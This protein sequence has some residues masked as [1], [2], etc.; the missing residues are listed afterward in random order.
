MKKFLMV[1]LLSFIITVTTV[2][3]C[4]C[5][6]NYDYVVQFFAAGKLVAT[7]YFYSGDFVGS[8]PEYNEEG[9]SLL[10]WKYK[11]GTKVNEK[12]VVTANISV[13]AKLSY[14]YNKTED[15]NISEDE[16]EKMQ[17]ADRLNFSTA[18]GKYISNHDIEIINDLKIKEI[19]FSGAEFENSTLKESAFENNK[20]IEYIV[21]PK[22]LKNISKEA[23]KNCINLKELVFSE[24]LEIIGD[25]SFYNIGISDI[26]LPNSVKN[27]GKN[28]FSCCKKLENITLDDKVDDIDVT[29]IDGSDMLTKINV[30]DGGKYFSDNG[31]LYISESG[32]DGLGNDIITHKLIRVPEGKSGEFKMFSKTGIISSHSMYNCKKL[33]SLILSSDESS[34]GAEIEEYAVFGCENIT[35]V[36]LSS[37]LKYIGDYAFYGCTNLTTI[38][39]EETKVENIGE[40]AFI[41]ANNLFTITLPSTISEIKKQ[42]FYNLRNLEEVN[43]VENENNLKIKD[44]AFSKISY[45]KTISIDLSKVQNVTEVGDTAFGRAYVSTILKDPNIVEV[46]VHNKL[47]FDTS[48]KDNYENLEYITKQK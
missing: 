47:T 46:Y 42:A 20:N 28:A 37:A 22:S 4:S 38:N 44:N 8:L 26:I 3:S 43:F 23:F 12:D 9:F 19:D 13:D 32:V 11:D 29:F 27:I 5:S 7:K 45:I 18:A 16:K 35:K 48:F 40:C 2:I 30:V 10:S 15:T 25:S 21:L 36:K 31:A 1:V 14:S 34:R 6:K 33:T 17:I 41:G 39:M 24:G